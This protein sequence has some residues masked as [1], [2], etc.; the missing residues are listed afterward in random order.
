[1]W[2]DVNDVSTQ[3]RKSPLALFLRTFSEMTKKRQ[4]RHHPSRGHGLNWLHAL[5]HHRHTDPRA[6]LEAAVGPLGVFEL[7]HQQ[8]DLML[9]LIH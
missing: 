7:L 2:N 1:M 5:V 3:F 9:E 4:K 8:V 6:A